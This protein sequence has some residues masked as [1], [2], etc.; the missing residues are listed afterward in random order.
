MPPAGDVGMDALK[1]LIELLPPPVHPL[2]VPTSD[3]WS[4]TESGLASLPSN[5][6]QFIEKYGTGLIDE[7]IWIFNPSTTN[8]Y[9]NLYSQVNAVLAS[10]ADSAKQFPDVFAMPLHPE[11]GGF[12]P[13]GSTNNGDN[14]F[15]VTKGSSDEWTVAVMGPR[16]PDVYRYDVGMVEF[17]RKVLS[18]EIQCKAFPDDFPADAPLEFAS[19]VH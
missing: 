18:G 15:W 9:V 11:P 17:L 16:S 6:R 13:F 5:Y 4:Q 1:H 7:F 2:E 3:D 10:L 19:R 14:L 8:K 12:L